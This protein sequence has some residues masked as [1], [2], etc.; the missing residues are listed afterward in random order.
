MKGALTFLIFNHKYNRDRKRFLGTSFNLKR[1]FSLIELAASLA[2]FL[3]AGGA[4]TLAIGNA[5]ING[6][7][8]RL[9]R[10]IR[11]E[12]S[13]LTNQVSNGPYA[14]LVTGIYTR[15]SA[16]A[17]DE[18]SSCITVNGHSY[19]V[20]WSSLA[21]KDALGTSND[22]PMTMTL[23]AS[24]T[25]ASGKAIAVNATA[26]EPT[27][28]WASGSYASVR[29]GVVNPAGYRG[30]VYLYSAKSGVAAVISASSPL[31]TNSSVS[32]R[33]LTTSCGLCRISLSPTGSNVVGEYMIDQAASA[34][35]GYI[36]DS[37]NGVSDVAVVIRK[38]S[39]VSLSL[40]ARN[41]DG[42]T[43]APTSST[44]G[45]ICLNLS[46]MEGAKTYT[47]PGCNTSSNPSQI[48]FST[49]TAAQEI[50][51]GSF[52]SAIPSGVPITFSTDGVA[53]GSA[54]VDPNSSGISTVAPTYATG[55]GNFS[56]GIECTS[57]TWGLP[58]WLNTSSNQSSSSGTTFEGGSYTIPANSTSADL[59]ATWDG[60]YSSPAAGAVSGDA[61]WVKARTKRSSSVV[62]LSTSDLAS[63]DSSCAA[64]VHC[65]SS[66]NFAPYPTTGR[67]ITPLGNQFAVTYNS[68]SGAFSLSFGDNDFTSSAPI[69]V[70]LSSS[71]SSSNLYSNSS[72]VVGNIIS[73]G[74]TL[75]SSCTALP[76]AYNFWYGS[77]GVDS[78]VITLT[79]GGVSSSYTLGL[80][81]TTSSIWGIAASNIVSNVN[82]GSSKYFI[83]STYNFAGAL[84]GGV[85]FSTSASTIGYSTTSTTAASAQSATSTCPALE[86]G[87][88]CMLL[89]ALASTP[90]G[91]YN[92]ANA[93][94][95][96]LFTSS[97]AA[98]INQVPGLLT[99]TSATSAPQ[100]GS[101]TIN[102]SVKD[103]NSTAIANAPVYLTS[104]YSGS[105]TWTSGV[106][107]STV[108]CTTN[109]S[110][111]CSLTLTFESSAPA[112][113]YNFS[114][115]SGSLTASSTFTV[116]QVSSQVQVSTQEITQGASISVPIHILDGAGAAV[117]GVTPTIS[118]L[119]GLTVTGLSASDASGLVTAT[120]AASNSITLGRH[121]LTV[122]AAGFSSTLRL[123]VLAVA[124]GIDATSTTVVQGS[125]KQI[126]FY[127]LDTNGSH[128][129]NISL[130]SYGGSGILLPAYMQANKNGLVKMVIAVP[131][132]LVTGSYSFTVKN[133][134]N[135]VIGSIPVTVTAGVSSIIA[136]QSAKIGTSTSIQLL[137]RD[138]SGN[139]V[140]NKS[141]TIKTNSISLTMPDATLG[142]LTI[143]SN[144]YGVA[145]FN[146]NA[147]ASANPAIYNL[148]VLA[149]GATI[150]VPVAVVP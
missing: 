89:S 70:T 17:S 4:V 110:G 138:S 63:Y 121:D 85:A 107:P 96:G 20:T 53:N 75:I 129:G 125:S 41:T 148:S 102:V 37:T 135:T 90:A 48:I 5:G 128:A 50:T 18:R 19:T 84:V 38:S 78:F 54:C 64:G 22:T 150:Q 69:T 72:R 32:L 143:T 46:Y 45:S 26:M 141:I 106:K 99:I 14:D 118:S 27:G 86:I 10:A 146:L 40:W 77:T 132:S 74:T 73:S 115:A 21:G 101:N 12:L 1:G 81:P 23:T 3:L 43:K 123:N 31:G 7:Q 94:S 130:S 142:S 113:T 134:N 60:S 95:G 114:V 8:I 36:V 103:G 139:V 33:Y 58:K 30:P 35:H 25:L 140:P 91:T 49:F 57:W 80:A 108:S 44:A 66:A 28:N 120:F 51:N 98:T 137:L 93:A 122:T 59:A 68:G 116:T 24:V 76:C 105:G 133:S 52:T 34:N 67:F 92:V 145:S 39:K 79:Q 16:C 126:S 117:S 111:L 9:E 104:V 136:Q 71:T 147:G 87:Q 97:V 61:L 65:S 11:T 88:A 42:S 127:A 82:Q 112:G 55:S 119:S 100:G 62:A 47:I 56:S 13:A 29:V 124:T 144:A 83:L 109:S 149:D 15:P 2:I 6:G 131:L